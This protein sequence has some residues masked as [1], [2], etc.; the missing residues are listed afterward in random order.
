MHDRTMS[1]NIAD[2][3]IDRWST[4]AYVITALS[5]A[6]IIAA[7]L[8]LAS[9]R[10]SLAWGIAILSLAV[11]LLPNPSA[12]TQGQ[13]V[14]S[15]RDESVAGERAFGLGWGSVGVFLAICYFIKTWSLDHDASVVFSQLELKAAFWIS[16]SLTQTVPRIYRVWRT[17]PSAT[18]D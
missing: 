7:I 3:P 14:P 6:G 12:R 15:Q 1:D 10:P 9:G 11:V 18:E 4:T 16:L 2:A 8:F 17:A 13:P 5:S